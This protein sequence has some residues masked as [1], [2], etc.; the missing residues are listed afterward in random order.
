MSCLSVW[1][2][3][4]PY[5]L[6]RKASGEQKGCSWATRD[7][8]EKPCECNPCVSSSQTGFP[9]PAAKIS[10]GLLQAGERWD[11]LDAEEEG[12]DMGPTLGVLCPFQVF[13]AAD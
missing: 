1:D 3:F 4:P 12:P 6:H 13:L 9:S 5:H 8:S 2:G 7:A 11:P 10:A